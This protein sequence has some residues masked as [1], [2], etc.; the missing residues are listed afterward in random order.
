ML[1]K[2]GGSFLVQDFGMG[3]MGVRRQ[4]NHHHHHHL[5]YVIILNDSNDMTDAGLVAVT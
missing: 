5:L 2:T 4:P 1:Q 3:V